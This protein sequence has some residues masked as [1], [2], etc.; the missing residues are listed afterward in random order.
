MLTFTANDTRYAAVCCQAAMLVSLICH[1]WFLSSYGID[2]LMCVAPSAPVVLSALKN[3]SAEQLER[4]MKAYK[5][6]QAIQ[7]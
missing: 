4:V 7:Q 5:N 3:L 1:T 6:H 2:D